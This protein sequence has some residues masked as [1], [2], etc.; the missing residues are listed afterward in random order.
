MSRPRLIVPTVL[1]AAALALAGCAGGANEPGSEAEQHSHD[2]ATETGDGDSTETEATDDAAD[3][4]ADDSADDGES[5]GTDSAGDDDLPVS[6]TETDGGA[7]PDDDQASYPATDSI[8]APECAEVPAP[9]IAHEIVSM[10]V[11]EVEGGFECMTEV[12]SRGDSASLADEIAGQL[13]AAGHVQTSRPPSD[14]S[15]DAVNTMSYLIGSDELHVTVRQNGATGVIIHYFLA[16]ARG[17][18]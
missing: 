9:P 18:G 6:D 12:D 11:T 8:L 1:A 7:G 16:P 4:G 15:V 2:V 14:D 10:E 5:Q 13:D 17:N 3:G